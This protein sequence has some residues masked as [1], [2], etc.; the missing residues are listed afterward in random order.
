[1][2]KSLIKKKTLCDVLKILQILIRNHVFI[3]I[4]RRRFYVSTLTFKDDKLD[5]IQ[6]IIVIK[7]TRALKHFGDL[8]ENVWYTRKNLIF[9]G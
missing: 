1:M 6:E 2:K 7:S 4:F 5:T 8:H 3:H 9:V